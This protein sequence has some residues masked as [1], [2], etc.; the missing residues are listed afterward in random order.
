[1]KIS[2]ILI[3]KDG[4]DYIKYLNKQFSM[5]ENTYNYELEYYIYENNSTDNT[6]EQIQTFF[7]NRKG[8]YWLENLDNN[9]NFNNI[10]INRGIYMANLRNKLKDYHKILDSEYT[11]LLD[12]DVIF[13]TNIIDKLLK[14]FQHYSES[15]AISCYDICWEHHICY[16]NDPYHYYDS[17][18]LITKANIN[19]LVYHNTCLFSSCKMCTNYR[20]AH[21]IVINNN[22]LI[23]NDKI[24][25]VKSA[26][27][28]FFMIK[29]S[30]YNKVKWDDSICEHHS[31]CKN[32]NEYGKIIINQNLKVITT[33]IKYRNYDQIQYFLDDKYY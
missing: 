29:T 1:M 15:V 9:E 20:L 22:L 5:I 12:C 18:A 16:S 2:I 13:S 30:I 3:I 6:K 21:N 10:S 7:K 33:N 26:F 27:G 19:S 11:L 25:E 24:I 4:E 14:T 17:F 23:S 32:I 28:G 8:H 31:F